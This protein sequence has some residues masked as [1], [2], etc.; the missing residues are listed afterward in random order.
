MASK[1]EE[2]A[3]MSKSV[4]GVALLG[5]WFGLGGIHAGAQSPSSSNDKPDKPKLPRCVDTK[6]KTP[7]ANADDATKASAG[8]SPAPSP[9]QQFPFPAHDSKHAGY[10]QQEGVPSA[11]APAKP[12][13]IQDSK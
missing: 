12:P 2:M 3:I 5:L 13:P 11:P 6:G 9:T 8:D 7:C 1:L 10:L 4:G